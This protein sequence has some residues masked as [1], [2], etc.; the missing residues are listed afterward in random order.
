MCGNEKKNCVAHRVEI[1][2]RKLFVVGCVDELFL[3]AQDSNAENILRIHR[4]KHAVVTKYYFSYFSYLEISSKFYEALENT[5][6]CYNVNKK[7]LPMRNKIRIQIQ[8]NAYMVCSH[9][10]YKV[11]KL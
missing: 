4:T 9:L 6:R 5:A 3:A 1:A 8:Y 2:R 7:Y 11:I 10:F